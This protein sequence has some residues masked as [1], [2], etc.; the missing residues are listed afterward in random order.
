MRNALA[1]AALDACRSGLSP[2]DATE[3]ACFGHS[4]SPAAR[5][6]IEAIVAADLA[7]RERARAARRR[8][9]EQAETRLTVDALFLGM[10]LS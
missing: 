7:A 6:R 2:A 4:L 5:D 9:T 1:T 8:V 10:V 3:L